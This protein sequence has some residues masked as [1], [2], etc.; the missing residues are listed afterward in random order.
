MVPDGTPD[1]VLAC[2]GSQEFPGIAV[3]YLFSDVEMDQVGYGVA[4]IVC[5]VCSVGWRVCYDPPTLQDRDKYVP[6][7]E[8]F[9]AEH[10]HCAPVL[11]KRWIDMRDR[12]A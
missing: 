10:E 5:H 7:I 12:H 8:A 4:D 1:R 3:H 9:A 11:I 2:L 6:V